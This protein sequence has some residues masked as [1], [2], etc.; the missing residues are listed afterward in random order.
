MIEFLVFD[1]FNLDT[2]SIKLCMYAIRKYL[3]LPV[4]GRLITY[5]EAIH[6]ICF[7]AKIATYQHST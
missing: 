3:P 1:C 6:Y 5:S 4:L 2:P 7:C